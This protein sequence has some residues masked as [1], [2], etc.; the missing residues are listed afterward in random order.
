MTDQVTHED[1]TE[2]QRAYIEELAAVM[3]ASGMPRMASR[4]YAA[5]LV[6]E[7]GS[8]TSAEVAATLQVSA[9]AVST[10]VQWLT[11]VSM[12]TRRTVPGSRRESYVVDSESLI[13]LVTHDTNALTAWVS[14]FARGRD[15]V[16]PGGAAADRL[17]E[18]EEF[19]SFLIGEMDGIMA[20]WQERQ[21]QAGQEPQSSPSRSARKR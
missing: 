17:A 20:R 18:L 2:A 7:R 11:Q 14:G 4:V 15:V 12:I 1:L 16:E 13:R 6:H 3:T 21:A 19:F 5:I 9:A 10:A 8:M